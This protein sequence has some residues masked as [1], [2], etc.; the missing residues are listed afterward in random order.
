MLSTHIHTHLLTFLFFHS[1]NIQSDSSIIFFLTT[2]YLLH[3][4]NSSLDSDVNTPLLS[5]FFNFL[6][7]QPFFL[8]LLNL[9]FIFIPNPSST[10]HL[11]ACINSLTFLFQKLYL[12]LFLTLISSAKFLCSIFFYTLLFPSIVS[13]IS[14][15]HHTLPYL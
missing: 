14:S 1:L 8:F 13:F 4:I 3:E 15:L 12:V 6:P 2:L 7:K 10:F 5:F 9:S 11:H